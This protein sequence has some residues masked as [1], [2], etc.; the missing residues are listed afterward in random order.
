MVAMTAAMYVVPECPSIMV[1][2]NVKAVPLHEVKGDHVRSVWHKLTVWGAVVIH[3]D[4]Q[5]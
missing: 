1:L 4:Q 5:M 2:L 3:T